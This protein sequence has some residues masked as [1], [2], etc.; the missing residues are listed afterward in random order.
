[1]RLKIAVSVV[2][3]RPWAPL[4]FQAIV[5]EANKQNQRLT[6]TR[7]VQKV[8]TMPLA[9]VDPGNVPAV[10]ST[11][12]VKVSRKTCVSLLASEKRSA[13]SALAIPSK[14]SDYMLKRWQRSSI[15]GQISVLARRLLQSE[16]RINWR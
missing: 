14:P 2:R 10:V 12:S 5:L 16:K 9:M 3:S 7:L 4:R 15:D 11:G 6:V 8:G 13:V 1:M